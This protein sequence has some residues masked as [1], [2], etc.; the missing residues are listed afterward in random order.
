MGQRT[1]L[2]DTHL[3]SGAKLVDFGGWDM[4]VLYS[5]IVDELHAFRRAA[6]LFDLSQMGVVRVTCAGALD[7]LNHLLTNVLH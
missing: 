6:G 2:Y 3:A 1:P 5:S 4:P 7:F